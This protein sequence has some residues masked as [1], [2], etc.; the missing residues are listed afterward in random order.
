MKK[1]DKKTS[2][3]ILYKYTK[4]QNLSSIAERGTL[5][6]PL[7]NQLNDPCESS[8][9]STLSHLRTLE[10]LPPFA[11]KPVAEYRVGLMKDVGFNPLYDKSLPTIEENERRAKHNEGLQQLERMLKHFRDNVGVLSLTSN[12]TNAVMWAHYADQSKGVCVGIDLDRTLFGSY[13]PSESFYKDVATVFH[14]GEVAYQK[15]RPEF[16]VD[17]G[18]SQYIQNAFFTKFEDWAYEREW[19]LLRP[20]HDCFEVPKVPVALFRIPTDCVVHV[21][22]GLGISDEDARTVLQIA[23]RMN[24]DVSKVESTPVDYSLKLRIVRKDGFLMSGKVRE[25]RLL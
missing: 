14:I 8:I 4:F 13:H 21:V 18:L 6:F 11:Y 16:R 9:E 2:R 12:P 23:G 20:L 17:V 24:F 5:A 22:M 7:V 25:L 15:L 1:A 10:S 19:R 3:M